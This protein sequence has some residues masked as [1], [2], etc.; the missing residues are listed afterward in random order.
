MGRYLPAFGFTGHRSLAEGATHFV[1]PR[2]RECPQPLQPSAPETN[3]HLLMA[4]AEKVGMRAGAEQYQLVELLLVNQDPIRLN[5][6]IPRSLQLTGESVVP[7]LGSQ[8]V[9]LNQRVDDALE[10]GNIFPPLLHALYVGLKLL[11]GPQGKRLDARGER[12]GCSR[13]DA[14]WWCGSGTLRMFG[15]S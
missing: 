14:R 3:S 10:L 12:C 4:L 13:L 2:K 11:G 5:V 8:R 7:V 1:A 6:A 15:H 9:T